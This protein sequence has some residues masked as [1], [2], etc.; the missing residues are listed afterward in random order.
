MACVAAM[1]KRI[2]EQMEAERLRKEKKEK[3]QERM[4]VAREVAAE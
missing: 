2:D 4:R 3:E 1:Q